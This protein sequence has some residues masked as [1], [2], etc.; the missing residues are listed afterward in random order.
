MFINQ[1]PG[2]TS[3]SPGLLPLLFHGVNTPTT[4]SFKPPPKAIDQ[5][6]G[7]RFTHL[8]LISLCK[9]A[10]AHQLMSLY[11]FLNMY[12]YMSR[13]IQNIY[14]IWTYFTQIE[15]YHTYL[16]HVYHKPMDSTPCFFNVTINLRD[17]SKS[18]IELPHF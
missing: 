12:M 3:K 5:R 2:K 8:V 9:L 1:L 4:A 14:Y 10:P 16:V 15:A 17:C 18:D 7:K 11:V 6:A 13:H